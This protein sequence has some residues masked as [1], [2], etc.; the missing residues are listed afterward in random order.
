[1]TKTKL[2]LHDYKSFD[3]EEKLRV[4]HQLNVFHRNS[5]EY[6]NRVALTYKE[7]SENWMFGIDILDGARVYQCNR[8]TNTAPTDFIWGS[9]IKDPIEALHE[10]LNKCLEFHITLVEGKEFLESLN[11]IEEEIDEIDDFPP[12]D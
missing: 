11:K 5:N 12:I 1:M 6:N 7:I 3:L 10:S 4:L 9:P 2:R 8:D